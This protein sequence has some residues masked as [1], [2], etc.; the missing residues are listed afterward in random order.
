MTFREYLLGLKWISFQIYP[1]QNTPVYIH[2]QQAYKNIHHFVKIKKFNA[3]S[4]DISSLIEELEPEEN[5]EYSWLPASQIDEK[6]YLKK[7]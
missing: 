2:I 5:W 3:V 4:F 1:T 7:K 6:A